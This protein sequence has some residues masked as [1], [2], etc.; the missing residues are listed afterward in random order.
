MINAYT[1]SRLSVALFAVSAGSLI[2]GVADYRLCLVGI[3]IAVLMPLTWRKQW[4][5]SSTHRS[6]N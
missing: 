4:T 3:A 6:G 2:K 5:R 1:L